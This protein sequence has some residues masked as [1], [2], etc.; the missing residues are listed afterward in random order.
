MNAIVA[1][2][3]LNILGGVWTP[4]LAGVFQEGDTAHPFHVE[5]KCELKELGG[6]MKLFMSDMKIVQHKL[7]LGQEEKDEILADYRAQMDLKIMAMIE[8]GDEPPNDVE[9]MDLELKEIDEHYDTRLAVM[10]R[11]RPQPNRLFLYLT[12]R[13]PKPK[14]NDAHTMGTKIN[15][16]S[17]DGS[18]VFGA[19]GYSLGTFQA[20]LK[21][22]P[23]PLSYGGCV[24]LK[25]PNDFPKTE[26]P[27][28]YGF[29]RFQSAK[30]IKI[31]THEALGI[32]D[33]S[34]TLR[35]MLQAA[36]AD[37]PP[38]KATEEIKP[39]SYYTKKAIDAWT[40]FH[41]PMDEEVEFPVFMKMLDNVNIF[42]CE[43]QAWRIFK[44]VD[45]DGS[46]EVGASEFENFLMAFDVLGHGSS[47]LAC[48]DIYESLKMKPTD[49]FGEFGHHE[50]MD[51]S[52][53]LEATEML[54]LKPG[55][56]NED[57]VRAFQGSYKIPMDQIYLQYSEFKK[58]WLKIADLKAEFLKRK[59]KYDPSPLAQARLRDRMYRII[60]DQE[61]SYMENLAKI[62]DVVEEVKKHRRHKK[63]EKKREKAA[64]K[65]AMQHEAAKF[66]ALR[67]QEKRLMAKVAEEE[68]TKKR[69]EERALRSKLLIQQKEARAR[70]LREIAEKRDAGER[71]RSD[72]I[73]AQGLDRLDMSVMNLRHLPVD[74]N[75]TLAQQTKL[76]YLATIDFSHNILESI[77]EV[78]FCYWM[79]SLRNFKLSQNRLV[80]IPDNEIQYL[81]KLEVL[82]L[83]NNRLE[84]FPDLCGHMTALQRLDI[85]N[86]KLKMLP[87]GLGLCSNLKFFKAHSNELQ[88]LPN[89]IGGCFRLEY[90]DVARNKIR[91]FPEDFGYL[92]SL[93]HLDACGNNIGHLP[94]DIGN[95]K[96]MTYLDLSTN[97]MVFLPASFSNLENLEI[98]NLERNE[99]ILQPG[100]FTNC[101]SLKDLRMKGNATRHITPDIG[102]CRS[103]MRFDASSNMIESIPTDIGLMGALEELD[104]SYNALTS[105]PPELASCGMI[106]SLNLR[107]NNIEGQFP[108]TIGLVESLMH[109]DLS[110]NKV[111]DLP[112]SI[113]GLKLMKTLRAERC[114]LSSV[115]H[116]ITALT[117]LNL[118]D[119]QNNRFTRFPTELLGMNGLRDLDLRN[120]AI[121]LLPRSVSGMTMLTRLDLSRNLLKALPVEFC[122]VLESVEEVTLGGNPWNDLPPKWGR[123][124]DNMKATDGPGGYSVADAVDFLYGM[125]AFY[126][127]AEDIWRDHGVFHYTNRLAFGDFLDELRKRIP[128][129]WHEGLVEHVKTLYFASRATGIFPRWYSLE[130]HENIQ[131]ERATMKN[132][133]AARRER[134]VELARE[135]ALAKDERMRKAYDVAPLVRAQRQGAMKDEHSLNLQVIANM[136]AAALNHCSIERDLL[137]E[138]RVKRRE[139]KMLKKE[140]HEMERLK[141]ILDTDR[142]AYLEE[143]DPSGAKRRRDKKK[144]KAAAARALKFGD[145][146]DRGGTPQLAP[147]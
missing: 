135:G 9:R 130:G 145:D 83:D 63:D 108:S 97:I 84:T 133:D 55:I 105:V 96:K 78:N 16:P 86:N 77:P 125:S 90:I 38:T 76:T 93:T 50:G 123:L 47:D 54:G 85:S 51:I 53:F 65:E 43:A 26:T 15:C 2:E 139:S 94:M 23:D 17:K 140:A 52:A 107:Y 98:C 66:T 101:K 32:A 99:L 18:G 88:L 109:I 136:E 138:K 95:C 7:N 116:T 117:N 20:P 8:R 45:V 36:E 144:K 104:L 71:L 114:Q 132:V 29:V 113:V 87:E 70:E 72:E 128:H 92:A 5:G 13:K 40:S 34:D 1:S 147:L 39:T 74:L 56:E 146:N 67:S 37:R 27:T 100:R 91:E 10:E 30:N 6:H 134:N 24:V 129:A 81:I 126:D 58:A 11:E 122:Q 103:L 14:M 64:T 112:K 60:T 31:H 3:R 46:G 75:A 22:I 137:A 28:I 48:L 62:N 127:C 141:E 19:T 68:K 21:D 49:A 57:I 115:P 4:K 69:G 120:N 73:R 35:K 119:L 142:E 118:L 79:N 110:F 33:L 82:E 131:E 124:W 42:L 44:A 89:S 106:Q 12:R 102:S 25:L 121:A 59:L 61:D 111:T 41:Y 80:K 143:L